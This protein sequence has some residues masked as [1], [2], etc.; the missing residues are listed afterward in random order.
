MPL[1]NERGLIGV[2]LL[3][4]KCDASLYIQVEMEIARAGGERLIDFHLKGEAPPPAGLQIK[5][6]HHLK[7]NWLTRR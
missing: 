5:N 6:D 1:W 4:E 7:I 3:G 2:L